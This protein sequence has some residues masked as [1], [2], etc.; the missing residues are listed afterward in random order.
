MMEVALLDGDVFIYRAAWATNK[1]DEATA[2]RTFDNIVAEAVLLSGCKDYKLYIT[3]K[4]NF[5]NDYAK[6]APYKGNRK[7]VDPPIHKNALRAHALKAWE[8]ILTVDEEADD[9]IAIEATKLGLLECVMVTIDKD[10]LQI[11]GHHYNPVKKTFTMMDYWSSTLFFYTQ[12]LTGDAVDNIIG[13]KGIGPVKGAKL[14]EGCESEM[15]LYEACVAAYDGNEDRV[16]ENA[17][18]LW[19]RREDGQIWQPP[20]EDR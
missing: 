9:A 12:I 19:L 11:P 10:F 7:A 3:G 15:E 17:R 13:L 4:G 16:I 18:L 5:R 14:L 8:A 20:K 1:E 6:T 2:I